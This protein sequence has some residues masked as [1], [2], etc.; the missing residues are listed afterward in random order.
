MLAWDALTRRRTDGALVRVVTPV[1]PGEDLA[2]ADERL[3]DFL[4]AAYP[5][6]RAFVPA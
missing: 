4:R 5:E 3:Q 6:V 2:V 1:R